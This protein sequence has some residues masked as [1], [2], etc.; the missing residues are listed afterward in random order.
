MADGTTLKLDN[1]KNG[2][3]GVYN[4]QQHNGNPLRCPVHTLARRVIHMWTHNAKDRDYLSTY[5][6]NRECSNVTAEDVIWHLKIAAGLLNYPTRKGIPVKQVN[7]HSHPGGGANAL[8]LSR[9]SDMQIQKMGQWQGA[10][11]REYIRE[12]LANYSDG[13]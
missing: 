3:K 13:M 5:F 7:T 11:F 9:Y 8:A 4:Y 1:Q 6:V 12:E 2:W 10:T